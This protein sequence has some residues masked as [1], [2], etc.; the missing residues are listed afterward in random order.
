MGKVNC[1][2]GWQISDV[3][4]P[5]AEIGYAIS[6]T[7]QDDMADHI[8]SLTIIEGRKIWEC[9]QCGRIAFDYPTRGN[10]NGIK[11]YMPSDGLPGNLMRPRIQEGV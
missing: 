3:G 5:S 6:D 9:S 4:C 8:P 2:C 11:W 10:P 1:P 7:E